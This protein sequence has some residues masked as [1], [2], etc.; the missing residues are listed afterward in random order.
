MSSH[1]RASHTTII[2]ALGSSHLKNRRRKREKIDIGP[3]ELRVASTCNVIDVIDSGTITIIK[4]TEKRRKR[5]KRTLPT[6][7]ERE[8]EQK[9][10]MK[11]EKSMFL[12]TIRPRSS[13]KM[14]KR[15]SFH[16]YTYR[17]RVSA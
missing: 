13:A 1:L 10:H 2:K 3:E 8:R 9:G 15:K 7:D 6:N 17:T 12:R 11:K 14:K 4:I 5:K 16:D